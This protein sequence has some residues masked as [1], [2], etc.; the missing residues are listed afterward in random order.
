MI[1]PGSRPASGP[2]EEGPRSGPGS[3]APLGAADRRLI[4]DASRAANAFA[5]DGSFMDRF[6][7]LERT[8]TPADD[9]DR[10]ASESF[11]R[12]P[13]DARPFPPPPPPPPTRRPQ[14]DRA[15]AG[16]AAKPSG[17]VA[18]RPR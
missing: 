15:T 9:E 2:G 7:D 8:P 18:P 11:G 14:P 3:R 12:D 5:S 4:D 16:V 1:R 10:K 6:E 13:D 17:N